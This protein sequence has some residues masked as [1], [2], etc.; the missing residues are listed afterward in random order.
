MGAG[1]DIGTA[2]GAGDI[3]EYLARH[4]AKGLLRFITCG[5][6]DD[7]KS[8]L[9]GRLLYESKMILEDQFAALRDD[10]KK[11]GT[12]GG[13]V[14]FALLVDGLTA[15]REQGITI[16]VAYRF[17][18]TDKRKFIVSDTPGHEQYT[19]NM[20]TGA[21]TADL[22]VILIDAR[23]GVLT[24]T[25]RHSYLAALLGIRHIV[26][27]VNKMDLVDYSR[28]IFDKIERDFREFAGRIQLDAITCI[29]VSAVV[30]DNVTTRSARTAW[31]AG[32]NLLQHLETVE[33]PDPA[34]GAAFRMPVQWVNRPNPEFRGFAGLIAGGA[35]RRG[36][37]L[38]VLPS[39]RTT[40]VARVFTGEGEASVG[41][42]GQSVTLTLADEI[43]VSR[44]DVLAAAGAPPAVANQFEATII[45]MHDEPLLQGRAY[46]LKVGTKTVTATVAPIKYR[47]NVNTL[48]HLAAK[49]LEL[50]DIGVCGLELNS[51]IA[52]EPYRDSR[53][54]GGF[55]LIDRLTNNTV[56]AG[57]LHFALRRAQNVHWQALDVNKVARARLSRQRPCILW[58]TGLSGAGKSTIANLVE[59]QL[60][61]DG[62]QTYLLDGD[63][64]RHGLNKDLGFTDQDRVENIRR[65]AE[66]ARLMVDAGLIVL[67]SFIS[68]FRSERRMAR[69]L[70]AAGEFMEVF[71]DTPLA[72]AEAR[73]AKG[74]YKKAR[75]GELKNFTG[76]D[77]PYEAP[78]DAEIRLDTTQLTPEAAALRVIAQ[79]RETGIID[80]DSSFDI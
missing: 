73:D 38:R 48:E 67:V 45:W 11:V 21:S 14:D 75:R 2:I 53:V 37:S 57:L 42:A 71:V 80:V 59:K 30:G 51:P 58:F 39:G 35:V 6:V 60:H 79:L 55:I 29:P 4:T 16:D 19:R 36:D 9:I 12:R 15:E 62:R 78:E 52:F 66:V 27:A 74:L 18:T 13:E 8:S 70:V 56:G 34:A 77:S 44:G 31:Y 40:T 68:P 10:S 61:A 25:R 5:S 17:F 26:V 22:A 50:N 23:K 1:A 41:L 49:K 69:A 20:V 72:L 47:V 64:V 3:E 24:Q 32:K 7:G 43:D 33:V 28:D 63:N 54:L 65:V 46:L 76:I